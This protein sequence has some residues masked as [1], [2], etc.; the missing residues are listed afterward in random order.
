MKFALEHIK[1]P[2]KIAKHI[3]SNSSTYFETYIKL[4]TLSQ[5]LE[6]RAKFVDLKA[7]LDGEISDSNSR[8]VRRLQSPDLP[9][10]SPLTPHSKEGDELRELAR[11]L[12]KQA[13]FYF[14]NR[15]ELGDDDPNATPITLFTVRRMAN[16]LPQLLDERTQLAYLLKLKNSFL[17]QDDKGRVRH[18]GAQSFRADK[19]FQL[20]LENLINTYREITAVQGGTQVESKILSDPSKKNSEF[21]TNRQVLALSFMLKHLGI[22]DIDKTVQAKFIMFL[23]GKNYKKIYDSV[24]EADDIVF[25]K[26]GEDARY[27]RDGSRS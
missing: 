3:N 9:Q 6:I 5:G 7:R 10:V 1:E 2:D 27:I 20:Q 4:S 17:R 12:N 21:T 25:I 13:D 23:I 24:R 22:K 19:D 16:F 14:N 8:L 18:N 26:G 11:L 15:K